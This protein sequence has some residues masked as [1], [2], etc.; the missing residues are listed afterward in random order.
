M[1]HGEVDSGWRVLCRLE[2]MPDG[3][4]RGFMPDGRGEDRLFVVRRG[5]R[6]HAY[7]N[8]CP[9]NGVGLE[10]AK[11]RFLNADG[12]EIVCY[13]HG[14]HFAIEDGLCTFGPCHGE[15]LSA[16]PVEVRDGEIRVRWEP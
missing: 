4:A 2:D 16:L 11:D 6:V 1:A 10:Y 3:A 15:F 7:L 9:H 13:V 12:S 5:P 8:S 14:A